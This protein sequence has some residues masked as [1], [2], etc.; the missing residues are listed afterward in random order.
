MKYRQEL[1]TTTSNLNSSGMYVLIKDTLLIL[2]R[3]VHLCK[4]SF[5]N[6]IM[7]R[8]PHLLAALYEVN[9]EV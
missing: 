2:D 3:D 8:E 4:N 9:I 6:D 5:E 1:K 7:M